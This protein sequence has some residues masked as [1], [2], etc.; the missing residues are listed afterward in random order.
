MAPRR[1]CC[2]CRVGAEPGLD[3]PGNPIHRE[4]RSRFAAEGDLSPWRP[5]TIGPVGCGRGAAAA[6]GS[7]AR[8]HRCCF[9]EVTS[10][11]APR[12]NRPPEPTHPFCRNRCRDPFSRRAGK[13]QRPPE[14]CFWQAGT[15]RPGGNKCSTVQLTSRRVHQQPAVRW[16]CHRP[17]GGSLRSAA[18][19][20]RRHRDRLHTVS[21]MPGLSMT[22]RRRDHTPPALISGRR[23]AA[24]A[25]AAHRLT[26]HR[27]AP[28]G[29]AGRTATVGQHHRW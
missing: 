8:A 24:S 22:T 3:S 14:V 26:A 6:P 18:P 7:A 1:C 23:P 11:A 4:T 2:F 9:G 21:P 10:P 15:P 28:A 5:H 13:V 17:G 19:Q 16:P 12:G 29:R 25:P 27:R 20:G